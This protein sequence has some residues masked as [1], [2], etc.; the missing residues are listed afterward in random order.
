MS[1]PQALR[2]VELVD[3]AHP[4][5]IARHGDEW[6]RCATI[7]EDAADQIDRIAA[8]QSEI[9]GRTGPSMGLAMREASDVLRVKSRDLRRGSAALREVAEATESTQERKRSI[10]RDHPDDGQ[11]W[12][13]R[14]EGSRVAADGQESAMLHAIAVMKSIDSDEVSRTPITTVGPDPVVV[15]QPPPFWPPAERPLPPLDVTVDPDD[16]TPLPHPAVAQG[17]GQAPAGGSVSIPGA[18]SYGAG[19][20][21]SSGSLAGA[22]VL[23]G[24][25]LAGAAGLAARGG[26]AASATGA[27]GTASTGA[28][29]RIGGSAAPASGGV[30]GRGAGGGAGGAGAGAAGGRG[31]RRRTDERSGEDRDLHDDG[32][33]WLDDEA[34]PDVLR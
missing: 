16:D 31:G 10:D 29:G 21:S 30:L 14:E 11:H 2:L 25:G 20:V 4:R 33:G 23:G 18:P 12:V 34:G 26:A 13:A 17:P 15:R 28:A 5:R 9:G 27:A 32:E 1:G 8:R 24:V 19:S 6:D 3:R 22:G 7:L